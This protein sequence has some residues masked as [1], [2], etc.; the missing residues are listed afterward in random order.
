MNLEKKRSWLVISLVA[1]L[2]FSVA[3][4]ARAV[5]P[6]LLPD[7]AKSATI[8]EVNLRQYTSE[9]TFNAFAKSLP[10]LKALGVKIL[11]LMPIQPISVKRK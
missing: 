1:T 7:W 11:W 4:T 8:Y 5:N 9:G 6:P 2:V 10:R 3:P